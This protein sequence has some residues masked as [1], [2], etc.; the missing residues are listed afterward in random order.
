MFD[1][2]SVNV[3]LGVHLIYVN[4]SFVD[5]SGRSQYSDNMLAGI[6]DTGT[7]GN[8]INTGM[9]SL[10]SSVDHEGFATTTTAGSG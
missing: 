10:Y 9:N 1:G 7:T 5:L 6:G 4:A 8:S 2:L 3:S